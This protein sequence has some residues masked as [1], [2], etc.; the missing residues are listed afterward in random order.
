MPAQHKLDSTYLQM[1][2]TQGQLSRA[3]RK[4][5][6][7]LIVNSG[8]IISDGYNG[9][10]HGFDNDCEFE[11]RF[12]YET[13]PEVIHAES[14]ALMKLARSTQNSGYSVLYASVSPCFECAKLIIQSKIIRVVYGEEYRD[15]SGIELLN[16]AQ[17]TTQLL[18]LSEIVPE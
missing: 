9:T 4:K 2:N 10:P 1:A 7:C 13:R 14:N 16:R 18:E 12:G 6:G 3:R 8:R 15:T 11:T 5:V 17:I